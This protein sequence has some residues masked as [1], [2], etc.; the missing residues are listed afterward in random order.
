MQQGMFAGTTTPFGPPEEP[1][2]PPEEPTPPPEEIPPPPEETTP[3]F[4][5]GESPPEF[6]PP[7]EITPATP[8]EVTPSTPSGGGGNPAA[9]EEASRQVASD[10][11]RTQLVSNYIGYSGAMSL[12]VLGNI[13]K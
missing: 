10:A 3:G 5:P 2:P 4:P 13:G 1:T 11:L 6:A 9:F 8:S 12:V 7:S